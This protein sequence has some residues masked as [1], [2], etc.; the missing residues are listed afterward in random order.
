MKD[1]TM[2]AEKM[3]AEKM[4]ADSE[5]TLNDE[6]MGRRKMFKEVLYRRRKQINSY[7]FGENNKKM[8]KYTSFFAACW[9]SNGFVLIIFGNYYSALIPENQSSFGADLTEQENK[10]DIEVCVANTGSEK[11]IK[12][13]FKQFHL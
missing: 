8:K 10:A 9:I 3:Q 1:G 5:A 2:E 11:T 12:G 6:K 13:I 7:W 4:Q